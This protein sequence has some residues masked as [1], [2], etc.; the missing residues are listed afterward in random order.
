MVRERVKNRNRLKSRVRRMVTSGSRATSSGQMFLTLCGVIGKAKARVPK[1]ASIDLGVVDIK[2]T[3]YG[4]KIQFSGEGLETVAGSSLGTPTQGMSIPA[5]EPMRVKGEINLAFG[6]SLKSLL[7]ETYVKD[8]R[9]K[10]KFADK[11]LANNLSKMK[12]KEIAAEMKSAKVSEGRQAEI[13]KMLPDRVREQVKL[14]L[15]V[16]YEIAPTRG[17][18][19]MVYIPKPFRRKTKVV[20]KVAKEFG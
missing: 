20:K 10:K 16:E 7:A 18:P 2:I 8:K 14:W 17:M 6:T 19:K 5:T 1:T 3:N 12:P 11:V 15:T 13:L 4:R 9:I